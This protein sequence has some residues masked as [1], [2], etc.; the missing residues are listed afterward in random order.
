M[1]KYASKNLSLLNPNGISKRIVE[2]E[3]LFNLYHKDSH[4]EAIESAN[5]LKKLLVQDIKISIFQADATKNICLPEQIDI[6]ITDIPYGNL[7]NWH[8]DN[9]ALNKM[10]NEI[11]NLSNPETII[12]ISMDKKQEIKSDRLIRLEKNNIGKRKFGIYRLA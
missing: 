4:R 3:D 7:V 12:A 5:K 8:G 2:L 1:L 10:L 6:I 9:D 11:I